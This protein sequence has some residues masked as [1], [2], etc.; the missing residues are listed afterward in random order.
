MMNILN[1]FHLDITT[2]L[3]LLI[4]FCCGYFKAVFLIFLIVIVHEMGHF[5]LF[6][7]YSYSVIRVDIYPFGGIT[8]VDKPINTPIKREI[9]IALG[10]VGMQVFLQLCFFLLFKC[11]LI[12]NAT[13]FLF[14]KYNTLIL[15]F[16]LLPIIP[17]DGSVLMHSFFE[18][19]FSFE[20]SFFWYKVISCSA[21]LL[22][23]FYN[24]FTS[25]HNYF[26]CMVLICQYFSL[27]K[28][29]KYMKERF[30]LE[31]YL[32]SFPY[33]KIQNEK[34]KNIKVLKKETLHFFLENGKFLHEKDFLKEKFQRNA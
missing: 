25:T 33:K 1:K 9:L 24:F 2:Y 8:R 34:T 6:R 15:L 20:C 27:Q 19:F 3:F 12:Q 17:L 30:Y 14:S 28:Q 5:L 29:E 31:R 21:F 23:F 32:Y 11:Q 7:F 13:Y 16:N 22:F 18:I 26:I 10:G 4:S